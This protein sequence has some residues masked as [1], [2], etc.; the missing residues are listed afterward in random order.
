[1]YFLINNEQ[2]IHVENF[3]MISVGEK[4]LKLIQLKKL[5]IET[6]NKSLLA[7]YL[8]EKQYSVRKNITV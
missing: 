3:F 2:L 5:I 1:M 6:Y 8:F 7:D 4:K